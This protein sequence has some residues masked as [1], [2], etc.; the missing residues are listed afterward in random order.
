MNIY[1]ITIERL[2]EETDEVELVKTLTLIEQE[3]PLK[4]VTK[5]YEMVGSD[6]LND[7]VV[8]DPGESV[9]VLASS[10]WSKYDRITRKMTEEG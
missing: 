7:L 1:G 5:F 3:G 2:N 10:G 4:T 8:Q 6:G 9:F